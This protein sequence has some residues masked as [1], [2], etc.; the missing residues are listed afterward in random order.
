MEIL[1]HEIGKIA[2]LPG[3]LWRENKKGTGK[4]FLFLYLVG[5]RGLE[6]RTDRL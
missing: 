1:Y 5:H 2:I 3:I 6:P 4:I